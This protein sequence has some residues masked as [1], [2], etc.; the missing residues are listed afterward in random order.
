M[1]VRPFRNE[2][3]PL[4][5]SDVEVE[6]FPYL[7]TQRARHLSGSIHDGSNGVFQMS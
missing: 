1:S 5:T 6:L 4:G 7:E 2:L 3:V